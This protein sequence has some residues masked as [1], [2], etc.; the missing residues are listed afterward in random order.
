MR[1]YSVVL[2]AVFVLTGSVAA[3]ERLAIKG[4]KII[5][6]AGPPIENGVIVIRDGKI[7]AVGKDV[8]IPSDAKAIDAS[9]KI[10]VPGFIEAH[11]MRGT[12]QANETNPN[13]PFLSVVDSIDPSQDYFDECRRQG[14]T[15]VAVVPGN[16]TMFGGQAA[17]VKTAGGYVDEMVVK[18]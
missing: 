15:A 17:I 12:D 9:G 7:E 3:Q 1:S 10:V 16:N 5:P 11:S 18:R 2:S 6:V 8:A 14:I 4:G 13:V